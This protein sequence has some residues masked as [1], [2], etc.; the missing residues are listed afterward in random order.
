MLAAAL[1]LRVLTTL[2]ARAVRT[3]VAFLTSFVTVL[4][5]AL[6]MLV[7]S[8][9]RIL[10]PLFAPL[11]LPPLLI[12]VP[13]APVSAC[14][15]ATPLTAF[16]AATGGIAATLLRGRQIRR[17]VEQQNFFCAAV[18]GRVARPALTRSSS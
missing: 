17:G 4:A 12:T 13:P 7:L 1:A 2:T 8:L 9:S 10:G 14:A 3:L 6:L 11:P 5:G 15:T 18:G 16:S